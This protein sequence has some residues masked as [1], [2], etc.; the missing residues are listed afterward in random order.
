M[1]AFVLCIHMHALAIE[2]QLTPIF[3]TTN[4]YFKLTSFVYHRADPERIE[5]RTQR[6]SVVQTT[7][8]GVTD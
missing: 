2:S 6:S 1:P 7:I 8:Q 3:T 4:F 5:Q